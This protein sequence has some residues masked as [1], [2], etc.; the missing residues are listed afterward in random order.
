MEGLIG[1]SAER[2]SGPY[3]ALRLLVRLENHT[4]PPDQPDTRE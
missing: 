1:L 4:A 3:G 2:Q